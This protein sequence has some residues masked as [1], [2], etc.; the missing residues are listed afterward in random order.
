MNLEGIEI[1]KLRREHCKC[2]CAV[3]FDD[4]CTFCPKRRWGAFCDE[5]PPISVQVFTPPNV[6]A[7]LWAELHQ[8]AL[9]DHPTLDFILEFEEKVAN[10]LSRCRC[11]AE[12]LRVKEERPPETV[13]DLFEWTVWIH[14]RINRRLGRPEF[15]VEEARARWEADKAVIV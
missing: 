8:W 12:W 11:L 5:L 6:G 3:N 10:R 4:P 1:G 14:N 2:D 13:R 9:S 7:E 15:S